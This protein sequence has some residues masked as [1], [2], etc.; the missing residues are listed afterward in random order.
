MSRPSSPESSCRRRRVASLVVPC[1]PPRSLECY[2]F[3]GPPP[4]TTPFASSPLLSAFLKDP[5]LDFP[6]PIVLWFLPG[7]ASLSFGPKLCVPCTAAFF[8]RCKLGSLSHTRPAA[9]APP[10]FAM[11]TRGWGVGL[12]GFEGRFL[13]TLPPPSQCITA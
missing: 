10:H 3:P 4:N 1:D 2:C 5:A 11:P 12:L 6:F 8:Q 9:F 13:N 7:S